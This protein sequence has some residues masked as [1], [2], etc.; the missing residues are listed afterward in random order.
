MR[1]TD[2]T[3]RRKRATTVEPACLRVELFEE[4]TAKK[5]A[6]TDQARA[7]LLNLNRFT[8]RRL[9]EPGYEPSVGTALHIAQVLRTKVEKL[10]GP[11]EPVEEVA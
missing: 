7:E 10:W 6:T 11:A 5:G 8:I 3:L 2:A 4:L 1:G 9:R